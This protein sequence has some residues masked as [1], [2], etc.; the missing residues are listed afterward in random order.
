MATG[1]QPQDLAKQLGVGIPADARM[2]LGTTRVIEADRAEGRCAS[3]RELIEAGQRVKWCEVEGYVE[4]GFIHAMHFD[5]ARLF[6]RGRGPAQPIG[7][8]RSRPERDGKGN[9][10]TIERRPPAGRS[11]SGG[12][13]RPVR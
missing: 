6:A 4:A 13:H 1:G 11:S 10:G 5:G 9:S 2:K 3:C 12:C 8:R 7:K